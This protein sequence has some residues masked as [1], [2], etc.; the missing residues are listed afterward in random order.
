[1]NRFV[2]GFIGSPQMNFLNARV[3]EAG[4]SGVRVLLDA[5]PTQESATAL[6]I[7]GSAKIEQRVVLGIRPEHVGLGPTSGAVLHVTATIERVE[8]LGA[9]SFLYCALAAG[10]R[11]TVHA[12]GQVD[13]Q[14][15]T[16]IAVSL[17]VAKTHVFDTGKTGNALSRR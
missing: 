12:P 6:P 5:T 8:Q 3:V 4:N 1:M 2:A 14:S 15:G 9:A 7:D 13:L 16:Q 11:L 10:E 17:P